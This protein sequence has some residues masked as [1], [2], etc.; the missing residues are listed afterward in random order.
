M[1]AN[2]QAYPLNEQKPNTAAPTEHAPIPVSTDGRLVRATCDN[3]TWALLDECDNL[4]RVARDPHNDPAWPH[5]RARLSRAEITLLGSPDPWADDT[6][7]Q[8]QKYLGRAKRHD[9]PL[10]APDRDRD[11]APD[12]VEPGEAAP[13]DA[14]IDPAVVPAVDLIAAYGAE[15]DRLSVL[16]SLALNNGPV[17]TAA[18]NAILAILAGRPTIQ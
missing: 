13:V 7:D 5:L 17:G 1:N 3:E 8:V 9:V 15:T 18:Q 14:A 4:F 2:P 6:L 16:M 10:V 11:G 12:R